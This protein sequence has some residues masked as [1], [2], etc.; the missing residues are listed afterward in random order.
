[1]PLPDFNA[2]GDLPEGVHTAT[3]DEVIARFNGQT[4]KRQ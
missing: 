1:M 2:A 4:S 3:L